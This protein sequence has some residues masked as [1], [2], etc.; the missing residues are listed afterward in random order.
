MHCTVLYCNVLYCN[1]YVFKFMGEAYAI[2]IWQSCH[3][4]CFSIH[5]QELQAAYDAHVVN[6]G[7]LFLSGCRFNYQESDA[8][9]KLVEA[10]WIGKTWWSTCDVL[11]HF[12][13]RISIVVGWSEWSLLKCPDTSRCWT[14]FTA[15]L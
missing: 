4:R 11:N 14:L 5:E 9:D 6:I 10:F 8:N 13:F 3:Q 15:R 12:W 2:A 7:A 1:I